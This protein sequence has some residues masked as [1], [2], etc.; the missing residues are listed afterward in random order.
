[1]CA[2]TIEI[3]SA[4]AQSLSLNFAKSLVGLH[5]ER[6]NKRLKEFMEIDPDRTQWCAAFVNSILHLQG[7]EGS[8]SVS[9]YPLTARSFLKWGKPAPIPEYGDIVVFPRGNSSWQGHVGFYVGQKEIDGIDYYV[10]LGGNQNDTVS[11]ELYPAYRAI[12]IRRLD[13]P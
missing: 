6:D 13:Q 5:E 7:Y 9:D 11:Y 3:E 2:C 1:M 4:N 12:D 10:I 8:E